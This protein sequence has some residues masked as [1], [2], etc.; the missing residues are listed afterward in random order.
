MTKAFKQGIYQVQNKAKYIGPT[1]TPR[2]LSS[3]EYEVFRKF[4][5]S[6]HVLAWGAE[7]VVIPYFNPVTQKKSRYIVDLYVK[8]KNSAGDTI[9][10]LVEI[11]PF[12]E[13]QK[14]KNTRGKK[15]NTLVYETMTYVRNQAKWAAAEKYAS[16][17]GMKFRLL[18]EQGIFF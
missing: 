4:D 16:E 13:T 17:R 15:R 9:E 10:E 14:P 2:F 5:L 3:W 11:K 6:P 1:P 12:K 7:C 18:S 8:Y